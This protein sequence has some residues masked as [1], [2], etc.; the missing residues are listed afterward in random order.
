MSSVAIIGMQWG[1]EGKG[2]VTHLFSEKARHIARAQ[3]GNNAG[4][5][6]MADLREYR[7]HLVPSGILYPRT[8]CYI[9]GGTVVDPASLLGE[10]EGLKK[11]GVSVLNRLFLSSY[12][13]IVTPYHR[14]IDRKAEGE[15]GSLSIG[16]TGRGIGPCYADKVNRV[17]IRLVDLVH[18]E[19]FRRKLEFAA[20]LQGAEISFDLEAVYTEYLEYAKQLGQYMTPVEEMLFEARRKKENILF[21]GAQGTFLDVTFGTYPFVTSSCTLSGGISTGLG[22]GPGSI[23]RVVGVAKAYTTRVGSGPFPTELKEGES[24]LFPDHQAA[25]EIGVTTGRKRRMGWLDLCM[26]RHAVV[27]NGVDS[28]ALMKLDVLDELETIKICV[29]YRCRGSALKHFPAL[30]EDLQEI[31]PIYETLPG[32]KC[33]TSHVRFQKDLPELAKKYVRRIEEALDVPISL[34]S[35]GPDREQTIWLDRLF[36]EGNS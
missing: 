13:H 29:G 9:G 17:G 19:I 18:P 33:S 21:E 12:C 10:I 24:D 36:E 7:F 30:T 32:W 3:G 2:K 6:V 35:V 25:R 14:A 22:I 27:L 26:L 20:K 34:I 8:K 4:H 31:E 16:T 23:D 15:R 1:D 28:L 5:T 11:M